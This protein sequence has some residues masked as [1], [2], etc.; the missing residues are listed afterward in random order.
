MT[1]EPTHTASGMAPHATAMSEKLSIHY[2]SLTVV[3]TP[4]HNILDQQ[5][6]EKH[7]CNPRILKDTNGAT[8]PSYINYRLKS[9]G[10]VQPFTKQ[11]ESR[12]VR[13][14]PLQSK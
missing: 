4:L 1:G 6:F 7:L 11:Y 5:L 12:T 8:C 2:A 3:F 14:A 13:K 10:Y 9:D